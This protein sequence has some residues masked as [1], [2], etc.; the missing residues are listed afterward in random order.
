MV[1]FASMMGFKPQPYFQADPGA[2][3]VPKVDFGK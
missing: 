2:Q 3:T 1:L